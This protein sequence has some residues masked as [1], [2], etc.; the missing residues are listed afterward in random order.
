[1]LLWVCSTHL[2]LEAEPGICV[3]SYKGLGDPRFQLCELPTL[4]VS[5]GPF[6]PLAEKMEFS[7]SCSHL[8]RSAVQCEWVCFQGE[9][10]RE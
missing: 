7:Q 2:Q 6:V 10:A 3:G 4:Q 8:H 1:M 5:Q 9:A